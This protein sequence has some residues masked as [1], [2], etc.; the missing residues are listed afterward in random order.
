MRRKDKYIALSN[1]SIYYTWKN[2]KK[3]YKNNKFKTS[4]PTWY[5]EFELP[6]WSYSIS[7]I[8]DYFEYILKKH[9]EKAVNPSIKLHI[10]KIENRITFKIKIGYYL[11]F[12]TPETM[13]LLGS[14]KSKI[15][16]KKKKKK[17]G[18]NEP[19]LRITE[20]VLTHCNV[21]H[22]SY[23]QNSRVLYRFVPNKSFGQLLN[24]SP[25]N[26]IFLKTLTQN[27]QILMYGLRIKILNHQR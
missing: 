17:N 24:I 1:L 12:S 9:G 7:D 25:E 14:T 19:L 27:F 21:V 13:K 20:V 23:Q 22:N 8:Q 2:I 15:K 26:F 6:D 11:E 16:K 10:N 4:A 18:E 5:E 3:S